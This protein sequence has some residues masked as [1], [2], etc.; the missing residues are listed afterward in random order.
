MKRLLLAFL[1]LCISATTGLWAE[2]VITETS[3]RGSAGTPE[4]D[5]FYAAPDRIAIRQGNSGGLIY[6]ASEK[7]VLQYDTSKGVYTEITADTMKQLN[8]K[9][10][11]ILQA[12]KASMEAQMKSMPKD[13]QATMQKAIDQMGKPSKYTYKRLGPNVMVG[14]W[15]C[16]PVD[17]YVDG[18]ENQKLW[19]APASAL[20]IST[21]DTAVFD[22]LAN[23]FGSAG[24]AQ[25]GFSEPG[26]DKFVGFRA[27]VVKS[28]QP[29]SDGDYISTVTSISHR[30]APAGTYK[31]P[32][33]LKKTQPF[34]L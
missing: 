7:R 5:T 13:Q 12:S 24:G 11:K 32:S 1:L 2:L 33:G 14:K 3:V 27:F 21:A 34:G 19:V 18:E 25:V 15:N 30:S 29:D 28:I 8:A 9:S 4:V 22:S 20:G 26:L 23:F 31:L 6:I 17:E 16:V 10:Q